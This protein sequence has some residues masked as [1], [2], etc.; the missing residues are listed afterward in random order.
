VRAEC[1]TMD[2]YCDNEA[3][4]PDNVIVPGSGNYDR[5]PVQLTGSCARRTYRVARSWGW[6]L[7]KKDWCPRCYA[8]RRAAAKG[9]TDG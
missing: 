9:A 8:K 4:H 3:A 5:F 6:F 7:G 1:Y 2:L